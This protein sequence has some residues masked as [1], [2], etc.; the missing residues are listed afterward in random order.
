MFS[1]QYT[2]FTF[3]L[4]KK[5]SH[6]ELF[7]SAFSRIQTEYGEIQSISPHLVQM[8]ENRD[9]NNSEYGNCLS[10]VGYIQS[11][12]SNIRFLPGFVQIW[13]CMRDFTLVFECIKSLFLY[14]L[15][16]NKVH[17]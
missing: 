9:Q 3:A 13:S 6:S 16:P 7:W 15:F 10:S 17:A 1:Q 11:H 5:Y 14:L 12:T 8:R 2:T 4:R